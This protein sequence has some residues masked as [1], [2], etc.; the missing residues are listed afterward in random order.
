MKIS[1]LNSKS[2]LGAPGAAAH[3]YVLVNYE[4]NTTNAPVTFKAT[5]E[6]LG[7]SI[8]NNLQLHRETLSGPAIVD[9]SQGAYVDASIRVVTVDPS[10]MIRVNGNHVPYVA[11]VRPSSGELVYYDPTTAKLKDVKINEESVNEEPVDIS[12]CFPVYAIKLSN[13]YRVVIVN[14]EGEVPYTET[15]ATFPIEQ[16]EES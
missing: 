8:A 1:E 5:I 16:S 9:V 15:I 14:N 6:E 3:S 10:N 11:I 12:D 7:K 2:F 13:E 4:D